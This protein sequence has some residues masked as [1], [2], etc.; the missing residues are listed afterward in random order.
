MGEIV[1][2]AEEA[3]FGG[4]QTAHAAIRSVDATDAI[5]GAAGAVGHETLLGDFRRD[6][7]EQGNFI[8]DVVE[9]VD[10]QFYLGAGLGSSRL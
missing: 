7:L 8:A 2:F 1:G 9:V 3:A 6:V 10:V 4:V 5:S